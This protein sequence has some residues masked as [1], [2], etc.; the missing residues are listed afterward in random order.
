MINDITDVTDDPALIQQYRDAGGSDLEL[1]AQQRRISTSFTRIDDGTLVD[2]VLREDR[3]ERTVGV[4]ELRDGSSMTVPPYYLISQSYATLR[5]SSDVEA[6]AA[7][8]DCSTPVC[9]SGDWGGVFYYSP[10]LQQTFNGGG[11]FENSSFGEIINFSGTTASGLISSNT[12]SWQ[13]EAGRLKINYPGGM[14]QTVTFIDNLGVEY[15][16][17]SVFD[18]GNKRFASYD[19][20]VKAD[21]TFDLG[22]GYLLPS[23]PDSYWNGDINAWIPGA[24]D[25]NGDYIYSQRFGWQ[26][27]ADGSADNWYYR[28][29]E[30]LDNNG[31]NDIVRVI[32]PTQ[33]YTNTTDYTAIQRFSF[34][35][36]NWYP[37]TRTVVNGQRVFYIIEVEYRDESLWFGG[38]PGYRVFIPPRINIERELPEFTDW[39]Y[40]ETIPG[41]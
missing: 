16:A 1:T 31:I 11:N 35:Q 18:D 36:R 23:T 33:G 10:G 41:M 22:S 8:S 3:S 15:G 40:T 34:A 14:Q 5:A 24:F 2:S 6:I 17:L 4:I 25:D 37:I 9:I 26:F 7:S 30:D 28:D 27:A 39:D 29:W 12:A 19:V 20:W 32:T 21:S 13:I 38:V